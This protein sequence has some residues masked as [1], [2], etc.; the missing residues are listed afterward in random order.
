MVALI[1]FAVIIGFVVWV[2]KAKS[3]P[4]WAVAVVTLLYWY[5]E[6]RAEGNIRADLLFIFPALL[7]LYLKAFMIKFGK[8]GIIFALLLATL[9]CAFAYYSYQLFGKNIG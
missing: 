5:W 4:L 9:N 1:I 6:S 7:L 8:K 3:I 2:L